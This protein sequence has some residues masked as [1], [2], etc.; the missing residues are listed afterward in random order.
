MTNTAPPASPTLYILAAS[1]MIAYGDDEPGKDVVASALGD[2]NGAC[3]AHA[4]NVFE[5]YYQA[6]RYAGE[7][8]AQLAIRELDFQGV[9]FRH[10]LDRPFWE[11]AGRIKADHARVSIADCFGLALAL[12]LGG[13]FLTADHGELDTLAAA[14]FPITFIRTDAEF[15]AWQAAQQPGRTP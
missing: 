13:Q 9:E 3:Y 1:A 5:V 14:G 11:Q 4:V 7:D 6:R 10:D 15:R 8:A 12:R 2:P